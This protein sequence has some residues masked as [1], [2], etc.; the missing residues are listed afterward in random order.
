MT[1]KIGDIVE[2][3]PVSTRNRQLR[4]QNGMIDWEVMQIKNTQCFDGEIGFDI[5]AMG[6]TKSRWVQRHEIIVRI[7]RENRY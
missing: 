7:C 6:S 5:K 4:K 1:I 3:M 2:L